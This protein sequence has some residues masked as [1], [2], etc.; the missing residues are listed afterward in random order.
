VHAVSLPSDCLQDLAGHVFPLDFVPNSDDASI[1]PEFLVCNIT[2]TA[3]CKKL[4]DINECNQ[5]IL[6]DY[7]VW[8]F[9][10]LDNFEPNIVLNQK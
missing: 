9:E 1:L 2:S 5:P 4:F 8:I 3:M 10:W 7:N 6:A